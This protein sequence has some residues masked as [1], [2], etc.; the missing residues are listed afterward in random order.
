[1]AAM[2]LK[3]LGETAEYHDTTLLCGRF[4]FSNIC[5]CKHDREN[6]N[7]WQSIDV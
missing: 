2:T 3:H 4:L 7:G 5:C 6:R 1:V